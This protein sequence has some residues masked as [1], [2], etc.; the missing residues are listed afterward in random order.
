MLFKKGHAQ[1][2]SVSTKKITCMFSLMTKKKNLKT[3]ELSRQTNRQLKS[4]DFGFHDNYRIKEYRKIY[5]TVTKLKKREKKFPKLPRFF[6][7]EKSRGTIFRIR[8][9]APCS[10]QFF[11]IQR[12]MYFACARKFV[13]IWEFFMLRENLHGFCSNSDGDYVRA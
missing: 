3:E 4:N 5:R 12:Y 13:D 11:A 2:T 10:G 7:A 6:S 1:K 9:V 8:K